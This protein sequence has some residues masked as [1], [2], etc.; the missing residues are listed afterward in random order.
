MQD[1]FW[2][3]IGSNKVSHLFTEFIRCG[4][5]GKEPVRNTGLYYMRCGEEKKLRVKTELKEDNGVRCEECS[6]TDKLEGDR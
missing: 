3:R 5:Q 6:L 2:A 1:T 4:M